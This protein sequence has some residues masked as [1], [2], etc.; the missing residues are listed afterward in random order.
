MKIS[1]IGSG[2]VGGAIASA[3]M[4]QNLAMEIVLID[5]VPSIAQA[6]ALDVSSGFTTQSKV[7]AGEIQDV[8]D[9]NII[10]LAAGQRSQLS[11]T[12]QQLLEVNTS[13]L[14]STLNLIRGLELAP[15]TIII[16]AIQ[17]IDLMTNHVAKL[18]GEKYS[19]RIIGT[20]TILE[21][22]L[23]KQAVAQHAGVHPN[24]VHCYV[25]GQQ[26]GSAL[27]AWSTVRIAG[28][29]F[30]TYLEQHGQH[31][32]RKDKTEITNAVQYAVTKAL[33][34]KGSLLFGLG[35]SIAYLIAC[36]LEDRREILTVSAWDEKR[37]VAISLP[38][39]IGQKGILE[40]IEPMLSPDEAAKL[41]IIIGYFHNA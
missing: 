2:M 32:D 26:G 40:T 19:N 8:C 5:K 37:G 18:F 10:V 9:S 41:E 35:Q 11:H 29:P 3:L 15:D 13:M 14:D 4:Q 23:F 12:S 24:N 21:T 33:H 28:V 27:M 38:R 36:I 16:N 31:L 39:V 1:I 25:L 22:N 30:E 17:P 20:G 7:R 6:Q 34:L